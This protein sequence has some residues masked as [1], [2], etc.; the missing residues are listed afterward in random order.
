MKYILPLQNCC[1]MCRAWIFMD[2]LV[3][4]QGTREQTLIPPFISVTCL[5]RARHLSRLSSFVC[6]RGD[7]LLYSLSN[8]T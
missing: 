6:L 4:R 2:I 1:K 8:M 5:R 7:V 3:Q